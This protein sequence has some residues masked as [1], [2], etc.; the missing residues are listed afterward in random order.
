MFL[1]IKTNI[2]VEANRKKDIQFFHL[3]C[4]YLLYGVPTLY[5]HVQNVWRLMTIFCVFYG[6]YVQQ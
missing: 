3:L 1:L 2:Y 4:K 5:Q 6:F